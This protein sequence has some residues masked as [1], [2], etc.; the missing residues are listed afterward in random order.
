[1]KKSLDGQCRSRIIT[2]NLRNTG[3]VRHCT[4]PD[5]PFA[6]SLALQ[7]PLRSRSGGAFSRGTLIAAALL[8]AG[9]I[10]GCSNADGA[11]RVLEA[12][13]FT[14]IQTHGY[15]LWGCG[16][17]DTWAT[18]FSATGPTGKQV[19]GVVCAGLLFKGATVR[20]D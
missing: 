2:G 10:S 5:V 20:F 13:G 3:R 4:T 8:V 14:D 18:K 12:Q 1:M 16:K 6:A 19:S 11:R 15:A 9:C 17:D 7:T